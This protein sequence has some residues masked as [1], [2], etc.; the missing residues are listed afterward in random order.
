MNISD[1]Q[2]NAIE[3]NAEKKQKTKKLLLTIIPIVIVA[4]SI[5][6]ILFFV[7]KKETEVDTSYIGN[8]KCS[9]DITF[10]V[11]ENGFTMVY[12]TQNATF[13]G[14]YTLK[15]K[16]NKDDAVAFL[17]DFK[18]T[19]RVVDGKVST[20]PSVAQYEINVSKDNKDIMTMINTSSYSIYNCTRR[21]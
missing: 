3:Y 16:H 7:L 9:N 5:I 12:T 17:I 14:T 21:K 15:E 20:S 4:C 1:L 10:D 13:S 2:N 18:A 6:V 11:E 19:R 8:W